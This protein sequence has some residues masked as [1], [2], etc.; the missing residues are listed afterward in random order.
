M[1]MFEPEH[2]EHVLRLLRMSMHWMLGVGFH[3]LLNLLVMA[4]HR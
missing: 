1:P 2:P 3:F 4:F